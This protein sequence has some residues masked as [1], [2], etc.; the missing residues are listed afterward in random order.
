M[1]DRVLIPTVIIQTVWAAQ[2]DTITF[3]PRVDQETLAHLIHPVGE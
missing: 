1:N 2:A 3:E